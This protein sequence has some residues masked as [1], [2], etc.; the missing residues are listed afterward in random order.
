MFSNLTWFHKSAQNKAIRAFP[1][2]LCS[3]PQADMTNASLTEMQA[4][5][6]TPL[7]FKSSACCT[8]PGR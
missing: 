7:A 6:C 5:S 3:F 8:N 4:S 1:S 2:A